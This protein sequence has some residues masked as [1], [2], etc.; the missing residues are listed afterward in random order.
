M[1]LEGKTA[2]I[3]GAAKRLGRAMAVAVAKN[4]TNV[5]IHY[6]R[7][8][9]EATALLTE[10]EGLGVKGWLVQADL[11]D[12]QQVEGLFDQ[13]SGR[14]G[15][16]DILINN[17]SIWPKETLWEISD[18][19]L[20]EAMRV[21][22]L[23]PLVLSRGFA[24]QNRPGHIIN[25]LDT[26]L[27]SYDKQ[28]VAYLLSKRSLLTLTRMLAL[29]LAPAIAVNAIAP[30]LILPPEGEDETYLQKLSHTNPLNRH[31]DPQDVTEA[32]LFL[33]GSRFV[34]GQIVYVD[35][36]YHMKGHLY[37]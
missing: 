18:A 27:T 26:R 28:H 31:G 20:Q 13:A 11:A 17:A 1:R 3:T 4:G 9:A 14:A 2:L 23:A 29:E 37:D 5:V 7:S 22:T 35:G 12:P 33:L 15:P 25:I 34:T 19:S 8:A 16:I 24:Q 21:H 30:G 6:H 10:I 36:G 32:V